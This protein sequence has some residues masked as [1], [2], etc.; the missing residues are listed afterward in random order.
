[1][2]G[3]L[4]T[5]AGFADGDL[6][7][8]TCA[9]YHEPGGWVACVVGNSTFSVV[10]NAV[11]K[12][13]TRLGRLLVLTDVILAHLAVACGFE[14]VQIW[15]ARENFDRAMSGAVLLENRSSSPQSR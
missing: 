14:Q 8:R 10:L 5:G 12:S 3:E 6:S 7:D 11:A 2:S 9:A 1:M 15:N 13:L 4:R